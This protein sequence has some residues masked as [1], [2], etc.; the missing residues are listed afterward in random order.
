MWDEI[1][2]N[3]PIIAVV[4]RLRADAHL[5]KD[6]RYRCRE[7]A[8]P[9]RDGIYWC[10]AKVMKRSTDHLYGPAMETL[11]VSKSGATSERMYPQLPLCNIP[12]SR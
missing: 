11:L 1:E 4:V 2:N 10:L 8:I 7:R 5:I 6:D 9:T 12:S 3:L